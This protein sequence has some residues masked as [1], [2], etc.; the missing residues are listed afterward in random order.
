MRTACRFTQPALGAGFLCPGYTGAE[1]GGAARHVRS[2]QALRYAGLA[3]RW[4]MALQSAC[5]IG[6]KSTAFVSGV[7]ALNRLRRDLR[8]ASTQNMRLIRKSCRILHKVSK[9][10]RIRF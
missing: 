10:P 7:V 9:N 3:A 5:V 8:Q 6:T 4:R 1:V 2:A